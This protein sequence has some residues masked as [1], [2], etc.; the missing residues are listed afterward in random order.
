MCVSVAGKG[1]RRDASGSV[2]A[3]VQ[4]CCRVRGLPTGFCHINTGPVGFE[5]IL[6]RD[7]VVFHTS[8]A[9]C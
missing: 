6:V 9:V 7:A 1:G 5:L 8:D 3:L 2:Q 4:R